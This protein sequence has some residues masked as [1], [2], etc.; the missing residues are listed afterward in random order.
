MN[1][2]ITLKTL[3]LISIGF[4]VLSCKKEKFDYGSDVAPTA[5]IT[6]SGNVTLVLEAGMGNWALF[7]DKIVPLLS[8]DY[9]VV[10]I[11]RAGYSNGL[12]PNNTRDA[13]T[14][15]QELNQL[16]EANALGDSIVLI[17]HSFGG[18]V[19]RAYQ[20][21][22]PT[23]VKGLV[24]LDAAHPD[25]FSRL[26]SEFN[27]LKENQKKSMKK[28]IKTAQRG[29]LKTNSGKKR[30]PTFNLPA[31]MLNDYYSIATEPQYYA[32]FSEEVS[33]FDASLSQVRGLGN[34]GALPLLVLASENSMDESTIEGVKNYPFA[35]HNQIWMN[36][37]NELALLSTNSIFVSTA[38]ANHYLA[39]FQPE[40]VSAQIKNFIQTKVQ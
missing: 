40:W 37:Q 23:H 26:P 5:T 9:K 13:A 4:S 7:Y 21:M 24:L 17:G 19:V 32:T 29:W 27:A 34:M 10:T 22:Y 38:S 11:S 1:S 16:V 18:L 25:Q 31:D 28:L 3:L 2:R 8:T 33:H 36:M 12:V 35:E 15:A 20:N 14:M 30:I 6:G 39:V